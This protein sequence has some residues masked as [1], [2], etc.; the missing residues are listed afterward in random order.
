MTRDLITKISDK[1]VNIDELA[2]KTITD[3]EMRDKIVGLMLNHQHIMVYYHSFYI[4]CRASQIKPELF[5]PYWD[6]FTSL[7][8]HPNSYHRNF[9]LALL[10]N[11]T[12]ADNENRFQSILNDY[13]LCLNDEKIMTACKCIKNTA[14][15]LESKTELTDEIIDILLDVDNRSDFSLKQKA[16]LKSYIIELFY[17]FYGQIIDQK[18]VAEFVKGELDNISPKTRK[19]TR[20]FLD[21]YS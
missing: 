12:P 14:K 5:Y 3:P 10:A 20:K 9:A 16:L 7:L 21:K 15:I 4:I 6:D 19:I 11:L 13:F 1:D 17:K 2:E 18:P 8:N